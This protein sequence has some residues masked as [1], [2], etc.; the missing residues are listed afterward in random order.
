M[1][2]SISRSW[3]VVFNNPEQHG[4]ND[5]PKEIVEQLKQEW[6]KDNPLRKGYW[7]YCE[8]AD[9]LKHVHMVLEH[10]GAM[11]FSAIKKATDAILYSSLSDSLSKVLDRIWQ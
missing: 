11:R 1:S 6:I 3:F 7:A 4:Y 5:T 9:G 8:S 10:S 2:E